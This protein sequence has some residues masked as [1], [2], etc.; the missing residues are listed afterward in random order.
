[1]KGWL[2]CKFTSST[3]YVYNT[4]LA[5]IESAKSNGSS[6][7][8]MLLSYCAHNSYTIPLLTRHCEWSKEGG[9]TER[10]TVT[11][12]C[13]IH[14]NR[15][16]CSHCTR[17]FYKIICHFWSYRSGRTTCWD[18][19][20]K[21]TIDLLKWTLNFLSIR[22]ISGRATSIYWN[23]HPAGPKCSI[24]AP[25]RKQQL[26]VIIRYRCVLSFVFFQKW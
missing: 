16:R 5:F 19:L 13:Q 20:H 14:R 17:Q 23:N 12:A 22:F 10:V 1:M 26:L 2:F 11:F 24:C 7:R 9:L 15:H 25:Y 8:N 18:Q 3:M 6:P 4:F 21:R